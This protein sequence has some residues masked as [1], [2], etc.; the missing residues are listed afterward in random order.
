MLFLIVVAF[1]LTSSIAQVENAE[2]AICNLQNAAKKLENCGMDCDSFACQLNEILKSLQVPSGTSG[3]GGTGGTGG[4]LTNLPSSCQEIPSGS[5]SGYYIIAPQGGVV[6]S[7]Y[8]YMEEICGSKGWTRVAYLNMSD[9]AAICPG[10]YHLYEQNGVRACGRSKGGYGCRASVEFSTFQQQFSEVCGHL[11]GFQLASPSGVTGLRSVSI[12]SVY[13]DGISLTYGSKP[14]K[15]IW[16]FMAQTQENTIS[17]SNKAFLCPCCNLSTEVTQA[18]IGN[19]YFCESGNPD[20][21]WNAWE[22]SKM[23]TDDPLWDGKDCGSY[24][25]ECC[26]APGI[27]WF[28]KVLD[29]S[30][31]DNL[32]LRVCCDQ[33][34]TDEDVPVHFYEIY[35]K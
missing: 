18:A 22:Y 5:P 25:T 33:D 30:T 9:P 32:E 12:D 23:Y 17:L 7:V 14:R 8:C 27:P 16:T 10:N 11:I 15:H 6:R 28:H 19:D 21:G 3:T 13:V 31:T 29:N 1:C 34:T 2:D 24:E 4:T 26:Q 20:P 35:I